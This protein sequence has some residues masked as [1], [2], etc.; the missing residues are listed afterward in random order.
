MLVQLITCFLFPLPRRRT[1]WR[2]P[3]PMCW[4]GVL[5]S[6]PPCRSAD[7]GW[8]MV[9]KP[10]KKGEIIT[11]S[12]V[13]VMDST[14]SVRKKAGLNWMVCDWFILMLP[15]FTHH[16]LTIFRSPY[17]LYRRATI[18]WP[19][20]AWLREAGTAQCGRA[21]EREGCPF[22]LSFKWSVTKQEYQWKPTQLLFTE[23]LCW[24]HFQVSQKWIKVGNYPQ[25][26]S[27][28]MGFSL[29]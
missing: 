3:T 28:L 27:I 29:S 24:A 14:W 7:S 1:W 15:S 6:S 19:L 8:R 4:P 20:K 25:N 2:V 22:P 18:A 9:F 10:G 17:F 16:K 5:T 23:Q 13:W 11:G 21:A 26:S 12:W